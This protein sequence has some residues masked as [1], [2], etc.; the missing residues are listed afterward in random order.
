MNGTGDHQYDLAGNLTQFMDRKNQTATFTYDASNRRT[1]ATY[2]DAIV[3]FGYDAINRLT[4]VSD[5]VG[6][7][8]TWTYDTVSGGHYSRVGDNQPRHGDRRIR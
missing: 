6:G 3:T 4:S 7:A 8:I 5:S 1:G 2:S